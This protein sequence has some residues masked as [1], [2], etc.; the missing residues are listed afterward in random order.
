M[1]RLDLRWRRSRILPA[2]FVAAAI[3]GVAWLTS[4]AIIQEAQRRGVLDGS[5]ALDPSFG[6]RWAMVVGVV[7]P[8]AFIVATGVY[9]VVS[10]SL[11]RAHG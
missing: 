3:A 2:L 9:V 1:D 6:L 7:A 4:Q 10:A 11:R 5:T 8:P